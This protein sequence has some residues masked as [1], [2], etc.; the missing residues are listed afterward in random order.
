MIAWRTSSYSYG[1]GNCV[2]V[3][4]PDWWR[5]GFDGIAV[6][7]GKDPDGGRVVFTRHAWRVNTAAVR[8]S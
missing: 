6:R 1:G 3:A 8:A 4:E 2:Q 5:G 7:D